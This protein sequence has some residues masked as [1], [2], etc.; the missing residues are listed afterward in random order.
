MLCHI[1]CATLYKFE[2]IK[3]WVHLLTEEIYYKN[4]SLYLKK[5]GS[6]YMQEACYGISGGLRKKSFTSL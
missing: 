2:L 4:L 3:P 1:Y 5:I 6:L